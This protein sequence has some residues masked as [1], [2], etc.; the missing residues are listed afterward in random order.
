MRRNK[1]QKRKMEEK[2]LVTESETEGVEVTVLSG[3]GE[4]TKMRRS[5]SFFNEN[6]FEKTVGFIFIVFVHTIAP[7][8]NR[9]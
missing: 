9:H 7:P 8:R 5:I 4:I 3:M 6:F 1:R 2:R